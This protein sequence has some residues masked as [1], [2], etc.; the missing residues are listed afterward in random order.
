MDDA[1]K[2]AGRLA[3]QAPVAIK[4]IIDSVNRGLE[5]TI[6]EGL[7]IEA[8]NIDAVS[9]TEDAIEGTMAFMEKRAPD[10]KGK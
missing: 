7:E 5:T 1:K 8:D 9:K 6:D 10:F 4:L 2:L 3:A